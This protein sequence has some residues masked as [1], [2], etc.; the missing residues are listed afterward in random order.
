MG[1]FTITEFRIVSI[2]CHKLCERG[3]TVKISIIGAGSAV[4]SMRLVG[5]LCK[6][7]SLAGSL[8]SLMDVDQ[9]RLEV[10]HELASR[11]VEEL[12]ADLKFEKTIDL[13]RS[14]SEADFVINT[15]LVGGHQWM[16]EAR[17]VGE[18]NGYYRGIDTQEFNM[19]SDYN[20]F[21]NYNQ[22][23][24]FLDVARLIEKLSPKAWLLQTANPVFEG[25]NLV[26]RAT[27]VKVAGFCHGFH[28]VFE[29]IEALGLDFQKVDWQVAGFNHAIWLNRFKYDG[30]DGYHLIDEWINSHSRNWRPTNPF[31]VQFSPAAIDMYRFYG[32]FPVGDTV[33]NGTWKYNRDLETKKKWHGEPWGG[34]DSEIGWRWY[35]EQL[36][37]VI[38]LLNIIASEKNFK[39]LSPQSYD[40]LFKS[41]NLPEEAI[42]QI[43]RE[44]ESII[45][46]EKPSGEQHVPFIK[47]IT[48]RGKERLVLNVPN[49]GRILEDIPE[50]VIV[51]VPV[52]VDEN[53]IHPE[54]IDPPL[55]R[56]ITRFYLYPRLVRME[57][58]LEAFLSGDKRVL[59]E[60]LERD[61]RTRSSD[62]VR[63][64]L[65]E[66]MNLPFNQ[67]MKQHYS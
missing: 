47:A 46:P 41:L 66:I 37:M 13:E 16:E 43:K 10:V 48:G 32:M 19:V 39:L 62:Q 25:T 29:I 15:A 67:E 21:S 11:Y 12:G 60:V 58:A 6:E 33:R 61:P 44:A 18:A 55:T 51:E 3:E 64:V 4:F 49:K 50:D 59:E 24:F 27:N 31:D 35:E 36:T 54:E 38:K 9:G 20:T 17:R 26:S 30:E 8:V 22:L 40:A 2:F 42:E 7:K 65:D 14:I 45:N 23:K 57:M 56:R 52:I 34:A 53:G 5:D 28:G 1:D 63:K